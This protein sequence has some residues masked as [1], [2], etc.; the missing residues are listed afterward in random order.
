[1][2]VD[3]K[4]PGGVHAYVVDIRGERSTIYR[5]LFIVTSHD[6]PVDTIPLQNYGKR[7]TSLPFYVQS[8]TRTTPITA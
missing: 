4:I 5:F 7:H 8:F 3:V 2:R 6:L 1:M